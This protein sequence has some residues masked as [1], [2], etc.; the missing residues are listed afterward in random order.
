[1]K[2]IAI[3]IW[4]QCSFLNAGHTSTPWLVFPPKKGDCREGIRIDVPVTLRSSPPAMGTFAP[5]RSLAALRP[6]AGRLLTWR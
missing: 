4:D 1:M 5:V 3:Y 2:F 6:E